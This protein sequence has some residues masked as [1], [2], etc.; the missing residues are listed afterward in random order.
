V[1]AQIGRVKMPA[2]NHG[3][4]PMQRTVTDHG[5]RRKFGRNVSQ[6]TIALMNL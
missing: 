3:D 4:D 6:K 2:L 5:Q 1:D